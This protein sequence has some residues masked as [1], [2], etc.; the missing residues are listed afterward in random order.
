VRSGELSLTG[1]NAVVHL[2]RLRRSPTGGS[3]LAA[4]VLLPV[5]PETPRKTVKSQGAQK[6]VQAPIAAT[7]SREIRGFAD[8]SRDDS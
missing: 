8:M 7:F 2:I 1:E 5:H 6:R 4:T 3:P